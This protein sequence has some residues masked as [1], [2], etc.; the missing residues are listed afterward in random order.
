MSVFESVSACTYA[1]HKKNNSDRCGSGSVPKPTVAKVATVA[2][3]TPEM[4][5][6]T[7]WRQRPA[8]ESFVGDEYQISGMEM[9]ADG[10]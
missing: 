10:R 2:L 4:A 5:T 3:V 6:T 1:C 9:S 7:E 8:R